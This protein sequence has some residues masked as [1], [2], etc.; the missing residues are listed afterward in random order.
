L[1]VIA[2]GLLLASCKPDTKVEAPEIRPV[3]TVTATKGEA[4]EI[5][6]LTGHIHAEDEPALGE[7][8]A[9]RAIA[10]DPMINR[11]AP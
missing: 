1:V 9:P 2:I 11:I 8:S 3:R 5:V 4:S 7:L 10:D 6:V